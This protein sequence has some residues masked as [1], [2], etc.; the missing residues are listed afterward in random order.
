M[1]PDKKK[2]HLSPEFSVTAEVALCTNDAGGFA[3]HVELKVDLPG[4]EH[5]EAE[6]L[7]AAAHT[8]CPYSNAIKNNV[9]VTLTVTT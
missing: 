3:L 7:V 2:Q 1:L 9:P 6:T 5:S 8:V 4:I